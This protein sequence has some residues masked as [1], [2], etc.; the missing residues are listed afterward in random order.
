M[1]SLYREQIGTQK[2]FNTVQHMS[3]LAFRN[4]DK[5]TYVDILHKIYKLFYKLDHIQM[6]LSE[7]CFNRDGGLEVLGCW[8]AV[9]MRQE[10]RSYPHRP[11]TSNDMYPQ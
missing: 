7:K 4:L 9:M 1:C 5:F 3:N 2:L 10:G 6:T 11:L 8:T